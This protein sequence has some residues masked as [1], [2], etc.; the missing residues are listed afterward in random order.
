MFASSVQIINSGL[1]SQRKFQMFT[2][3]FFVFAPCWYPLEVH[4]HSGSI[5]G[6]VNL[7]KIFR[8]IFED[9]ED[10]QT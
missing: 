5:L 8:Q 1:D 6:S 7:C 2:L 9:G 10:A 4:Q 3:F